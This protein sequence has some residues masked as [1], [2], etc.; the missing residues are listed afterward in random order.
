MVTATRVRHGMG[1]ALA[2]LKL[3]DLKFRVSSDRDQWS[4]DLRRA[5]EP[6]LQFDLIR[7]IVAGV[8]TWR[9]QVAGSPLPDQLPAGVSWRLGLPD[10]IRWLRSTP[11]AVDQ[12]AIAGSERANDLFGQ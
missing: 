4:L 3:D 6:W 2:E 9:T 1:F 12:V 5:A 11:T 8:T 7:R 10:A